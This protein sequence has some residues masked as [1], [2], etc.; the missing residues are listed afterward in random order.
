MVSDGTT[1][2]AIGQ[3]IA[4]AR[5]DRGLTQAELARE[6]GIDR[7]AVAKVE[8]GKRK[9]S[10]TELVRLASILDRPIDWFVLESPPAVVSRREARGAEGKSRLLDRRIESLARDIDF[11]EREGVLPPIQ[12]RRLAV[13]ATATGAEAAAVQAR[14]WMNVPAGPLVE[15]QAHC[16]LVGLLGFSLDLGEDGGDAAYVAVDK[17]G[18]ALI[19]G[20]VDPRRRR[21]NLAHEL[22][23]H[24]FADAYAPE[25]TISPGSE[26]ERI[27][28][29]FA[30]HVL[31]P[32]LEVTD[33][34]ESFDDAR[35]AAVAIG[36]RFRASWSAVCAQLK[37]LGL[38]DNAR[39]CDLM[40][41]PPTA[42]DFIELGERWIS[43][44]DPP[45]VPSEYGRR[46]LSTYRDG[47][48]TA[49]RTTELLWG[50][51]REEELPDR[52]EVPLAGLRREFSSLP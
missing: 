30:I 14:T 20:S 42:A 19:N 41:N 48:L 11:L 44:L 8:S 6:L 2:T 51:V 23:H 34:W 9:T 37:N 4:A 12:E 24:L 27:I 38:L 50:T 52:R 28:N 17:W 13:P 1:S 31:L 7:T 3:R 35:L 32:R 29:A 10:A 40:A 33:V 16:E 25:M 46:L 47:R 36:V 49:A 22:G 18:V 39:R 5:E 15:L 26:T 45:S 43:E 21:F